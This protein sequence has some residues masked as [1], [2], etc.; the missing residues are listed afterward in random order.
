MKYPILLLLIAFYSVASAQKEKKYLA[1]VHLDGKYGF[2]DVSGHE[3]IPLIYDAVGSWGNNL[4]PVNIG[5]YT[6][7]VGLPVLEA[8]GPAEVEA[9]NAIGSN[10]NKEKIV[11][12]DYTTDN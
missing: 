9:N 10:S 1:Q 12:I 7:E 4:V 3:V 6:P 2:I 5:K 8:P 11:S